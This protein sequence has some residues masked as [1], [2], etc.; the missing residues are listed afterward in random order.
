MVWSGWNYWVDRKAAKANAPSEWVNLIANLK[1]IFQNLPKT[2]SN[3]RIN[4]IETAALCIKTHRFARWTMPSLDPE[5][6]TEDE[7]VRVAK[8]LTWL[9]LK[10]GGAPQINAQLLNSLRCDKSPTCTLFCGHKVS[11]NPSGNTTSTKCPLCRKEILFQDFLRNANKDPL[12]VQMGHL[13]PLSRQGNSHH[14][15]NVAWF[16]RRCNYINGENTLEETIEDLKRIV[17]EHTQF[18]E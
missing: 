2:E 9:M 1:L 16:H 8:K 12:G 17:M 6:S 11:C 4:K 10:S 14:A 5:Y 18:I 13:T 3:K 7:A 15:E